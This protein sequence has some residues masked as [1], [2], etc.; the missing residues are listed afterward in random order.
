M[1]S[2]TLHITNQ[3]CQVDLSA[4]N[5]T[6]GPTVDECKDQLNVPAGKTLFWSKLGSYAAKKAARER[7]YLAGYQV[8]DQMWKD[9]NWKNQFVGKDEQI[10][11][12]FWNHCSQ[13]LAEASSGTA[14]IFVRE[15]SGTDWDQ[16]SHWAQWEYPYLSP[17]VTELIRINPSDPNHKEWI[18]GVPP[19]PPPAPP[20]PADPDPQAPPAPPAPPG[21]PGRRQIIEA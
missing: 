16:N 18:R 19:P 5:P 3:Y 13:A 6:R 15:G 12:D 9:P 7:D 10:D 20:A 1:K 11:A 4:R 8:M 21:P 14:Y 17:A 2:P